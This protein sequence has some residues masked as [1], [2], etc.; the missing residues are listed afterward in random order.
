MAVGAF[1]LFN[2]GK[3]KLFD[4][5]FDLN[6]SM[7]FKLALTTSSQ[8]IAATFAGTS[9]DCRYA[10]L[11]AELGTANGYTAGGFTLSNVTLT[12]STGTITF[13]ADDI[14]ATLS[15]GITFKYGL[16]YANSLANKDLLGFVDFD[17]GGGSISAA[18]GSLAI[19]FHASGLFTAV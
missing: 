5:T 7:G 19:A 2:V 14:A 16:V 8:A 10:D 9:T 17:T 11:T 6:G 1:T 13:D 18:A 15:G 4:G 3:L 12:R